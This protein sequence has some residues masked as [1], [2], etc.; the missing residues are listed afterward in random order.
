MIIG[1]LPLALM[2][3]QTPT[4]II[5]VAYMFRMIGN[6]C[7]FSPAMSEAFIKVAP[8]D[9]SHATALNNTLRQ[10]AGSIS[11]TIMVV[12]ADLP[13]SLTRGIHWSIMFTFFL[14]L[15]LIAVFQ[16]YLTHQP[17]INKNSLN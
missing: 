12:I 16:I 2:T 4:W 7:V 17:K 9:I 15:T 11:T 13:T 10:V 1:A 5:V 14:I 6:S 8:L 3:K